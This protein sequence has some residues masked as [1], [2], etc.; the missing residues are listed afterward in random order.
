MND[1]RERLLT[2]VLALALVAS[3]AGVVYL[4]VTPQQNTEPYTELYVLGPDGNA[5]DYP[6]E[7]AVGESGTLIVGISNHE[8]RSMQYTLVLQLGSET[9]GVRT[10][11]LEGGAT[12]EREL[13]F[14]AD[15]PGR[16]HLEI[17]LYRG[18]EVSSTAE[19]YRTASLWVT[20]RES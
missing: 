12:W 5:S 4:S 19:P 14:A 2:W 16:K 17:R 7:L 9:E 8:H 13:S 10:V 18:D 20:V 6:K 15:S 3:L 11:S 1:E